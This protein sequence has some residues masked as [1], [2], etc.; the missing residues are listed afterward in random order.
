[1]KRQETLPELV[2]DL[3]DE[4]LRKSDFVVPSSAMEMRDGQI[5]IKAE[6]E[7][8]GLNELL[9]EIGIQ[10]VEAPSE[11][12][13]SCLP[14]FHENL[15]VRLDIPINYYGKM[16]TQK[17][18][19][20]LDTNVNYWLQRAKKNFFMRSFIDKDEK[21][22]VARALL[23]D[24][25]NVID[26]YDVLLATL[27]AVK[28]SG[29][30][31]EIDKQGC[32]L[33]DKSMY[34]RFIVPQLEVDAPEL[35]K[36]YRNPK[37]GEEGESG[38]GV[39]SG[40]VIRNSEVGQGSFS[41]SP[42]IVVLK[43]KNGLIF[44]DDNFSKVH[45]GARMDENSKINW[46]EETRHKNYQLVISQVKDAIKV[47]CSEE[48]LRGKI[49]KLTQLGAEKLEHPTDTI[50]NV[51]KHLSVTEEKEKSILDYFI[52]G[53]DFTVM[54]VTQ[55]LTFH[56]HETQDADEQFEMESVAVELMPKMK[57]FDKPAVQRATRVKM[58]MN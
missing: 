49:Q 25:Y 9:G 34:V 43:C 13:L 46:S 19:S 33:T 21:T 26:N 15:A 23:S 54:G 24:R 22:G 7:N 57:T 14:F 55:A 30:K 27:E 18:K 37:T 42:R 29:I 52:N 17:D 3:K 6:P 53:G 45:L 20:L 39:I 4:N 36:R 32:D 11:M 58:K 5:I 35:L 48:Y 1:M 12:V 47:F 51:S 2:A 28:E 16:Q 10:S 31:M 8:K 56:A 40:F 38:N 50:K 41:I 44:K